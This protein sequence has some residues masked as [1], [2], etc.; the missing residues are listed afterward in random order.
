MREKA[1]K[2]SVKGKRLVSLLL[3]GLML[4]LSF[5]GFGSIAHAASFEEQLA[6]FHSFVEGLSPQDFE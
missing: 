4:F 2:A 3:A 1:L 5:Q 6:S